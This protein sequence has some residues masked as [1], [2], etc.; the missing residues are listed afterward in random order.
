MLAI[1]K[2]FIQRARKVVICDSFQGVRLLNRTGKK[3]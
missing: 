1:T 2:H 3:L